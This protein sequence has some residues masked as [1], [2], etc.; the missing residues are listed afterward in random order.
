MTSLLTRLAL[1]ADGS[2]SL[3]AARLGVPEW[4]FA[5]GGKS[6]LLI[7]STLAL[8]L[9]VVCYRRTTE[10]LTLRSRFVLG[11]LRFVSL[12]LL[13]TL[14][15]GAVL[16]VEIFRTHRPELLVL[17]DDSPSMT[18]PDADSTRLANAEKTLAQSGLRRRL[19]NNF[20]VRIR[21]T[22]GLDSTPIPRRKTSPARSSSPPRNPRP[23]PSRTSC[24]SPTACN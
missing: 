22:S 10:G 2:W 23:S 11:A 16:S 15:S 19:E 24:C 5:P 9:V 4:T 17:V 18:L 8:V 12:V 1:L 21:H 20:T 13:L 3:L 7:G 6:L 14:V